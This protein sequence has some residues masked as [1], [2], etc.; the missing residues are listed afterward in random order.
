MTTAGDPT[1]GAAHPQVRY[2]VMLA[3]KEER[4]IGPDASTAIAEI[5]A[6]IAVV[7]ADGFD[8]A[9][10]F[11]QGKISAIGHIGAVL[12]ELANGQAT[13]VLVSLASPI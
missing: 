2:R 11:M 12:E 10:A 8:A 13:S 9:V 1:G 5:T 4:T 3:K 7:T 6:P